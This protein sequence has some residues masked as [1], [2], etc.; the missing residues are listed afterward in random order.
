VKVSVNGC[1]DKLALNVESVIVGTVWLRARVS[2]I[3]FHVLWN[4][5][6]LLIIECTA[7]RQINRIE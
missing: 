3:V 2:H 4:V 6:V 7:A 1:T 5:V